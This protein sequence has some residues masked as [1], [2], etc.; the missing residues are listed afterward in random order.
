MLTL[1]TRGTTLSQTRRW[2]RF[3]AAVG[4][5]SPEIESCP[6]T[7]KV[8][9]LQ[10]ERL[11]LRR[12][13]PFALK[14]PMSAPGKQPLKVIFDGTAGDRRIAA[15]HSRSGQRQLRPRSINSPGNTDGKVIIDLFGTFTSF[16]I[17]S[18]MLDC[19]FDTL[20]GACLTGANFW[21]VVSLSDANFPAPYDS[22]SSSN[23]PERGH[24]EQ[25]KLLA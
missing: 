3:E 19:T 25:N 23:Q 21:S 11:F 7:W 8:T 16:P 24:G 10:P 18:A 12:F 20:R 9:F 22:E 14:M 2:R 5:K 4:R 13:Q 1:S 17:R 15:R 6:S